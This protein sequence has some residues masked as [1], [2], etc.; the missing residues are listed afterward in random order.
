MSNSIILYKKIRLLT[1]STLVNSEIWRTRF[2]TLNNILI[3]DPLTRQYCVLAWECNIT[4]SWTVQTVSRLHKTLIEEE[5][6][7]KIK[8]MNILQMPRQTFKETVKNIMMGA[9]GRKMSRELKKEDAANDLSP[10]R[11]CTPG[12]DRTCSRN[13]CRHLRSRTCRYAGTVT[14]RSGGDSDP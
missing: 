5:I 4:N 14:S 11:L 2:G 6:D 9:E 12:P 3:G 10:S 1:G 7:D 13:A 8:A